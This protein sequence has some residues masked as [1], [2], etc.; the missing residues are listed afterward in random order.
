MLKRKA[1][2]RFNFWKQHKTKQAL[3]VTGA[4]QIGKTF[5]IREFAKSNYDCIIEFNLVENTEARE[6]FK[7]AVNAEDLLFRMSLVGNGPMVPG[8]TIVFLDEIQEC[9]EIVTFIKFLVEKG[10]CDYAL[11]GSLLGV[12]LENIRSYPVGYITEVMMYP[13][14]FEEFC[15]AA[16]QSSEVFDLLGESLSNKTAVPDYVH[17]HLLNLYHRYLLVGGMPDA[18]VAYL[19]DNSLDQ[20]RIIQNNIMAYYK[21]D[22]SKYAPKEDRLVIKNI[23]DLIPSELLR[24]NR[25]FRFSSIEG[26]KRY[27]QIQDQFL[28]LTKANVALPS[29]N[30]RAPIMPLLVNEQH[31]LFKLFLSDIGLLTCMYGRQVS[32]NLLDGKPVTAM[33][34]VYENFV[35]Q[36]LMAHGFKLRYFTNKKIGELDFVLERKDGS[37]IAIEVKS[38]NNYMTHAA[39]ANALQAK[40]YDISEAW[41]LAETNIHKRGEVTY[42]PIYL[43]SLLINE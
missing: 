39:L 5:L 8:N 21:S 33:G 42:L 26:V 30:I 40:S 29:F 32:L 28:W 15:W 16:G 36:E 11:S 1:M 14:D 37:I 35:A 19:Q 17:R 41:V 18:I 12:E 43:A 20:A 31:N 9:P 4:R 34:G 38:G 25:R 23:Y 7:N 6:S 13:L 22:I 3:L 24:Q 2:E 10:G 27:T